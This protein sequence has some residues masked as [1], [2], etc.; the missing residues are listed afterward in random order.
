MPGCESSGGGH[1]AS[2]SES[3]EQHC[4]LTRMYFSVAFGFA[5]C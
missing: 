4:D 3:P 5:F 1:F 2:D